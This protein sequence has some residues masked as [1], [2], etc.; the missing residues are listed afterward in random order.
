MHPYLMEELVKER[1]ES[2]IEEARRYR[3][4]REARNDRK[5]QA[6]KWMPSASQSPK[7]QPTGEP[8]CVAC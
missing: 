3:L 8:P 2:L 5:H 4:G 6:S 1:M 7:R